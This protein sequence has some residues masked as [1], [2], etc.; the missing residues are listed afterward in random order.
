M[1]FMQTHVEVHTF[2]VVVAQLQICNGQFTYNSAGTGG[3]LVSTLQSNAT[4]TENSSLPD[5]GAYG[6]MY[7]EHHSTV[8]YSDW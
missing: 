1:S 4:L 8:I 5:K 6:M 7:A 2:I 3:G